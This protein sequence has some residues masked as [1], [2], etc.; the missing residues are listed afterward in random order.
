MGQCPVR[1]PSRSSLNLF[2]YWP[3]QKM[4]VTELN[5]R[6]SPNSPSRTIISAGSRPDIDKLFP[7]F[8]SSGITI[9]AELTLNPTC[10][11]HLNCLVYNKN[12]GMSRVF[13]VFFQKIFTS[14]GIGLVTTAFSNTYAITVIDKG[15][16]RLVPPRRLIPAENPAQ[17]FF[18]HT[19]PSPPP[20]KSRITRKNGAVVCCG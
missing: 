5:S 16:Q 8:I 18:Q 15:I 2:S 6:F 1:A 3:L 9:R 7:L 13:L 19:S 20:E 14:A 17:V 11:L 4:Q 10:P 12:G